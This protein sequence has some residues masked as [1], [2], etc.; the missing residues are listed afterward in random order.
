MRPKL[1][2]DNLDVDKFNEN[3]VKFFEKTKY[4]AK[5]FERRNNISNVFLLLYISLFISHD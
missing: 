2:H 1:L 5:A 4:S 3:Q